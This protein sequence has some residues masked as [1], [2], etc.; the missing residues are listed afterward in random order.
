MC[1]TDAR[2]E[3]RL[4]RACRWDLR[5][6]QYD[7]N[8]TRCLRPQQDAPIDL[9][10]TVDP[11]EGRNDRCSTQNQLPGRCRHNDDHRIGRPPATGPHCRSGSCVRA[12]DSSKQTVTQRA[13]I[14][15]EQRH[16]SE[17]FAV[18]RADRAS[19]SATGPA[20][21]K[22]RLGKEHLLGQ[23]QDTDESARCLGGAR[24]SRATLLGGLAACSGSA[25][26]TPA[27]S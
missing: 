10:P 27:N 19:P 16:G 6:R 20:L 25:G 15:P 2:N 26:A 22:V 1:P 21:L 18:A 4:V 23:G 14:R 11:T 7:T 12:A 3:R 17:R 9:R 5:A 8:S 13:A 24:S